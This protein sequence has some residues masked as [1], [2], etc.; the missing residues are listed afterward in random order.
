MRLFYD[1][2]ADLLTIRLRTA[3]VHRSEDLDDGLA[4]L[5]DGDERFIG[6]ELRDARRRLTLEELTNVTY[7]NQALGRR[8][9]LTLP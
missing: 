3:R 1:P 9:S 4:L 2:Q 8:S 6:F 7:E 5:L